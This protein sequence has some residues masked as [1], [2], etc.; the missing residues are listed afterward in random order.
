MRKLKNFFLAIFPN[1]IRRGPLYKFARCATWRIAVVVKVESYLLT[2][3]NNQRYSVARVHDSACRPGERY[4]ALKGVPLVS[5]AWFRVPLLCRTVRERLGHASVNSF[6]VVSYWE[7]P[8]VWTKTRVP[9]STGNPEMNEP[10]WRFTIYLSLICRHHCVS[11]P[12]YRL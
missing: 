1:A 3:T 12:K 7:E 9:R 10:C 8:T 2:F 11:F 5:V 6:T 4:E